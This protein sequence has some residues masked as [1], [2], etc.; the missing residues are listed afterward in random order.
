MEAIK[1]KLILDTSGMRGAAAGLGGG[2]VQQD[3]ASKAIRDALEGLDTPLIGDIG[4]ALAG[5]VA[6]LEQIGKVL[7][8]GFNFLMKSSPI[9]ASS[10]NILQKS[11]EVLLR[12]IG[13][14]IGLF[15]KPFA[16]AMLRFAIPIYK[17][18]REFLGGDKAQSGLGS[19][20]EGAGNVAGG[21][22]NLDFAQVKEGLGQIFSGLK[23]ITGGFLDFMGE[24]LSDFGSRFKEFAGDAW[25]FFKEKFSGIGSFLGGLIPK[26]ISDALSWGWGLFTQWLEGISWDKP[27][28][29][30]FSALKVG[31]E[32]IVV[33]MVDSL[34]AALDERLPGLKEAL[35]VLFSKA[36]EG[37][38]KGFIQ[39]WIDNSKEWDN[40]VVNTLIP[41]FGL[42]YTTAETMFGKD[43]NDRG[44]TV[45]GAINKTTDGLNMSTEAAN[46]T[47]TALYSIPTNITTTH[48][49]ITRRISE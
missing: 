13:D 19:I 23:D 7:T 1:A 4:A 30:F 35:D 37:E 15:I 10:I 48:T 47:S 46:M 32:G 33:P 20:N 28:S 3:T 49:I 27:L 11:F 16:I 25:E 9:L 34:V 2:R 39:S 24:N 21:L 45:I 5:G 40:K 18:W 41:G 26:P 14:A 12:P 36:D 6:I 44:N 22:I 43:K 31:W 17:K 8:N 42:L 38:D 29:P